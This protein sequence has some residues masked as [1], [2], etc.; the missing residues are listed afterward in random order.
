MDDTGRAFVTVTDR[1]GGAEFD[2]RGFRRWMI[3]SITWDEVEDRKQ[4]LHRELSPERSNENDWLPDRNK[5][6]SHD[7]RDLTVEEESVYVLEDSTGDGIADRSQLYIRDF[8]SE[9]TDVAGAVLYY[10]DEVFL[11]VGPDMWRLKDT[12]DDGMA[13]EKESISHGYN[14]HIGF[15]GHGMSGLIMGPDGRIYWGIGDPGLSVVD[16]DGKRWHYPNQGAILRSNPDGSN[17]EVFARGVRNTHEFTFDKFG[18]LIGVDNDGDHAGEHER[19]VHLI[20][21]SDSGWRINWQFGKYVDPKNNDYK[22]WMD[23]EYFKPRFENQAA[24]I[25]PPVA[26]YHSGPAGMVYNPGTALGDQWKDHFFVAEFVGSP[27]RSAIHA[28]SLDPKGASFELAATQPIMRGVLATGMDIGPDGALYFTDWIE[29]WDTKGE[30]RIWKLD[31]PEHSNS[32]IRRETKKLLA[33]NFN[34]HSVDE[35]SSLLKHEDMRVRTKAQFELVRQGAKDELLASIEQVD[36]QLAR[37]HGIWGVGQLARE[38]QNAAKSLVGYLQDSDPEIRTQV[39]KVLGDVRY[40]PAAQKI[41]PLL[42]D[43]HARARMY[44]AEALGRMKHQ[45]AVQPIVDMLEANDDKDVYLRH[46]GAVALARIGDAEAV[47]ALHEHSSKAVRIAA[48]VAL[49]RMEDAGIAEF[50][51]DTDEYIVT[52]AARAINDDTFIDAALP[53]LAQM[54]DQNTFMNEPL[55]RRSINANLFNG[56]SA[57]A[58][59]LSSF[60]AR[61]GVSEAMRVEA[62]ATLGVWPEPSILDRVT[63]RHRGVIEHDASVAREAVAPVISDLLQNGSE[64]IKVAAAEVVGNLS[65]EPAFSELA[66][67][68]ESDPSEM[69]R[70]ASLRALHKGGYGQMEKVMELALNDSERSVRMAALGLAPESDI[71]TERTVE[72]LAAVLENNTIDEQQSALEILGKIDS[73]SAHSV[74]QS[75]LNQLVNGELEP[76]VRLDLIKAVESS[77]SE[78]LNSQ[79]DKYQASKD[80]ENLVDVYSEAMW[81]GDADRGRDIFYR[82]E[83]AQCSRCHAIGDW[84]GSVG[85]NLSHVGDK[86]S[87]EKLLESLVDPGAD[88]APGYGMVTVTLEEGQKIQGTVEDETE[89][90]LAIHTGNGEEVT[91]QKSEVTERI[92]PP[93]AMPPMGGV[94]TSSELRDLVEFMSTLKEE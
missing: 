86:L 56:T 80:S 81:G 9:E 57:D 29:G 74:L 51:H 50:L 27:A 91:V 38:Q 8:N 54:L 2:I 12:D 69:V 93:S 73:E 60:A 20:N 72:L 90:A 52:N 82:H 11:G 71:S 34:E 35:L 47:T 21:G 65:H 55:I 68:L 24:H 23:E 30:G 59:R 5:D 15:S 49:K 7:W 25:L 39:A 77:G 43:K 16:Q 46:A 53:D 3:E 66:E 61:E 26:A 89:V 88:I 22:V 45:A 67:L 33:D 85:P 83:A 14:V 92:N 10:N 37:V 63:G 76:E 70:I 87:R 36:H 6:G 79:L 75:H 1:S 18:N 42:K 4:F 64:A 84:G 94:L 48:V 13:D 28:F 32:E 41:I 58:R 40:N 62:L 44:A 19:L 31:T 17:F 78:E